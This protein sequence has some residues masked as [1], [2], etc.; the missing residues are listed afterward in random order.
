M[1]NLLTGKEHDTTHPEPVP[2]KVVEEAWTAEAYLASM[3]RLLYAASK[4]GADT[5]RLLTA[6]AV[7]AEAAKSA[8]AS[9]PARTAPFGDAI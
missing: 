8:P 4:R 3:R 7:L 5:D 2:N 1:H 9:L 6:A